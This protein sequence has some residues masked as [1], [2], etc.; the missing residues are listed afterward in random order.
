MQFNNQKQLLLKQFCLGLVHI[1][2]TLSGATTPGQSELNSDGNIGLLRTHQRS[3]I[4]EASPPDCSV[5]LVRGVLP[6]WWDIVYSTA[7]PDWAK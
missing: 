5:S 1:D 7:P 2:R 3:S 6:L 4:S